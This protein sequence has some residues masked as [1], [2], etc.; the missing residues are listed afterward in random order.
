M[1]TIIAKVTDGS[2]HEQKQGS[3]RGTLREELEDSLL[4]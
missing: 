4:K 2:E 3:L 1:R